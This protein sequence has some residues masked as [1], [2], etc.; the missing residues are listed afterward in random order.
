MVL[1][2]A[3]PCLYG[4]PHRSKYCILLKVNPRSP[5]LWLLSIVYGSPHERFRDDLWEEL[6]TI[7]GRFDL[8][9]C[10]LGDF[11]AVLH[12]HEK[13]E[14]SDFNLRSGQKFANC[15]FYCGLVGLG[16]KGSL[17]TW[18]SG[19]LQEHLDRALANAKWQDL[20]PSSSVVNLPLPSSDHCGVWLKLGGSQLDRNHSYFKFLGSWLDHGNF[21]CQGQN[22]WRLGDSWLTNISRL[23]HNLKSWNR[24]VYGNLFNRKR[25]LI[26]RIEGIDK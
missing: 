1:L 19:T 6:R 17:F 8:P 22:A 5:T 12:A 13:S 7:H 24:D 14:S 10:V 9:W 26:A 4:G 11:N 23:Q 16:Y 3:S 21:E 18:K 15:I 2:E 20:F 25:C